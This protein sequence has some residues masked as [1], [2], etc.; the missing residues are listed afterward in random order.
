MLQELRK[1]DYDQ[2][3]LEKPHGRGLNWTWKDLVDLNQK[4]GCGKSIP[5]LNSVHHLHFWAHLTISAMEAA[6]SYKPE[7]SDSVVTS[8]ALSS[9]GFLFLASLPSLTADLFIHSDNMQTWK[10]MDVNTQG[11]TVDQWGAEAGR[12]ILPWSILWAPN[13]EA[14]YNGSSEGPR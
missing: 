9:N 14:L 12:L 5:P 2:I 6:I 8:G 11:T 10:C 3:P 1:V 7:K 4:T 13:T